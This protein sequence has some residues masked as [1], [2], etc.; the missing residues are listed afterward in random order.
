MRGVG[1][2]DVEEEDGSGGDSRCSCYP[3]R[4]Q[5]LLEPEPEPVPE[6]SRAAELYRRTPPVARQSTAFT[7]KIHH[8]SA[9]V[10][11]WLAHENSQVV[12][13][14]ATNST[15]DAT[16]E[17]ADATISCN[18]GSAKAPLLTRAFGRSKAAS[19][20]ARHQVATEAAGVAAHTAPTPVGSPAETASAAEARNCRLSRIR[21]N[22]IEDGSG[23]TGS[24]SDANDNTNDDQ[25]LPSASTAAAVRCTSHTRI[26]VGVE[27]D[28]GDTVNR[29]AQH[30]GTLDISTQ[31]S[32]LKALQQ[33][34][35]QSLGNDGDVSVKSDVD[36]GKGDDGGDVVQLI[37]KAMGN[38]PQE[39][40]RGRGA[41]AVPLAPSQR[42]RLRLV[43]NWGGGRQ[44]GLSAITFLNPDN[45]MSEGT[46]PVPISPAAVHLRGVSTAT[47][48]AVQRDGRRIDDISKIMI[49]DGTAAGGTSTSQRDM[50]LCERPS[51]PRYLDIELVLP[52]PLPKLR[53]WNYNVAN[54][55]SKG[56][57]D[58]EAFVD[59]ELC[60]RGTLRKGSSI[61][62]QDSFTDILL[63]AASLEPTAD[64][65][66]G[67]GGNS[68]SST[69]GAKQMTR[70]QEPLPAVQQLTSMPPVT[71]DAVDPTG[72][73]VVD[74]AIVPAARRHRPIWFDGDIN[75]A[76]A[77]V[78]AAS[79]PCVGRRRNRSDSGDCGSHN[80]GSHNGGSP[81]N[82]PE[83]MVSSTGSDDE[84]DINRADAPVTAASQPCVGRRHNRND[85]G[86]C[87]SHNGGSSCN[88]P[89]TMVSSA[90]SDDEGAHAGKRACNSGG[91]GG[92]GSHPTIQDSWDSLS[93]FRLCNRSRELNDSL[94]KDATTVDDAT[95]GAPLPLAAQMSPNIEEL[96]TLVSG[97]T[98][99]DGRFTL[100][101]GITAVGDARGGGI[102]ITNCDDGGTLIAMEEQP[103]QETADGEQLICCLPRGKI[104]E[105]DIKTTW[106]D[107]YYV[108]LCG[109]ELFDGEGELVPRATC[110][111]QLRAN[112]SGMNELPE[113]SS[114]PRRVENLFDG[115]NRTCDAFHLWLAPFTP[116][117][118]HRI[119]VEFAQPT[120]LS[121]IRVWNYNESRTHVS[122]GVRQMEMRMDGALFFRGE[123][124]QAP[125]VLDGSEDA[126]ECIFLT[127]DPSLFK[128]IE[129]AVCKTSQSLIHAIELDLSRAQPRP[130]TS[131]G[132]GVGAQCDSSGSCSSSSVPSSLHQQ[133]PSPVATA[134]TEPSTKQNVPSVAVACVVA[135]AAEE[136][137][138]VAATAAVASATSSVT[139][140]VG[141]TFS[142]MAATD[143]APG[144]AA[145]TGS[146]S[147]VTSVIGASISSSPSQVY[148]DRLLPSK[149]SSA[150]A[151]TIISATS[152]GAA[153]TK[154][155]ATATGVVEAWPSK[156]AQ[157]VTLRL[158]STW[159]DPNFIGLTAVQV[160]DEACNPIALQPDALQA[161]PRDLHHCTGH[162]GD[163][164]R[165]ENLIDPNTRDENKMWLT[166]FHSDGRGRSGT[167]VLEIDL[168]QVCCLC[169]GA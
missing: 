167:N 92:S 9:D 60:W 126:A 31:E 34:K 163:R 120:T 66:S 23:A 48:T 150:Q 76:D 78:T 53:V 147:T 157:R 158:L 50:W 99:A 69:G 20:F 46:T 33:Q 16:A 156:R 15:A 22:R 162:R 14:I 57:K 124:R 142:S 123:I 111:H 113:Y 106:G 45:L 8:N 115:V 114:D 70:P 110:L 138:D 117:A 86:D 97:S 80:D 102:A 67:S 39:V 88:L 29:I 54:Q 103:R 21:T 43:S 74:T 135:A 19:V 5:R 133:P 55:E 161:N 62:P 168:G 49:F 146:R 63:V 112:P 65:F 58:V 101:A 87:G 28:G 12:K 25:T 38:E 56:V 79:Q 148:D 130:L 140:A 127:K 143:Q 105:L 136:S 89:E 3:G 90:G 108:G 132:D 95:A 128:A 84:G 93:T 4:W 109:L 154:S 42:V 17:G 1:D 11:R 134:N 125:G 24:N 144:T 68:A 35:S 82:L 100:P 139:T 6:L 107:R 30:L 149:R 36:I 83:T 145:V 77:P 10:A 152:T 59:G 169:V 118:S 7:A 73:A 155:R 64:T 47:G 41:Y 71:G 44:M 121:M 72:D 75:R 122:R 32:I 98:F 160:L 119:H 91:H 164:R 141:S 137:S 159:G 165:L 13:R 18:D 104:L 94:A 40:D 26:D 153:L 129:N 27:G 85:S 166:A 52:L 81:C 51:P 96:D 131:G 151:P 116:G 2:D 37:T 61:R